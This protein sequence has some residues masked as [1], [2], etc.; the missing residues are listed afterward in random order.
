MVHLCFSGVIGFMLCS[1][2]GPAVDFKHPA[3]PIDANDA[4][5]KDP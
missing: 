3:N 4:D 1:T 2:E 5:S